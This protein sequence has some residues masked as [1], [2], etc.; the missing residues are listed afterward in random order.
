MTP[1]RDMAG[2][3]D[4][5]LAAALMQAGVAPART[6]LSERERAALVQM[7]RNAYFHGVHGWTRAGARTIPRDIMDG[8]RAKRYV[9]TQQLSTGHTIATV[10]PAGRDRLQPLARP[11]P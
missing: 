4:T 9:T 7:G 2:E 1:L 3:P 10:T 8:L 6:P 5:T 11:T